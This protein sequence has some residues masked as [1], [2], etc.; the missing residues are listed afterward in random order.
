MKPLA[1]L[2]SLFLLTQAMEAQVYPPPA[3]VDYQSGS[4]VI[5]PPDSVPSYTGGLLGY[6]IYVDDEFLDFNPFTSPT[7]TLIYAFNPLPLPGDRVFCA[8]AVYLNWISDFTCDSVLVYYG[9]DIPFT[10]DWSS[11]SLETNNWTQEDNYW[12]IT[13]ES[14]NPSP[15]VK[16]VGSA[17]LTGYFVPLTSYV[18]IIDSLLVGNVYLEFDLK[19]D[20]INST[21]D[22]KLIAQKWDWANQQWTEIMNA[23]NINGSL[24]WT[25]NNFGLYSPTSRLFKIRFVAEGV[26]STDI[27]AW[28]IDNVHIFRTCH[29]P[30]DLITFF[31]DNNQVEL[32]WSSWS[33]GDWYNWLYYCGYENSTSIGT[34]SQAEFDVAARWTPAQLTGYENTSVSQVRFYPRESDAVYWIRIWEGD[35][36]T[37]V[38]EQE[39]I[40]PLIGQENIVIL[41]NEYS[42]DVTQTLWIGYHVVTN[43]GYP[44]GVDWGPPDDGYGNMM[45]WEGQ[46]QT[47]L[48]I[49][50]GLDYNWMII[51][52]VGGGNPYY[53][54]SRVYR[55]IN[56]GDYLR[57]ADIPMTLIYVD[58]NVDPADLNCYMVTDVRAKNYDTCESDYSNESCLQPVSL[59][60]NEDDEKLMVYPNPAKDELFVES[61]EPI[62]ELQ[63]LDMTG[64]VVYEEDNITDKLTIQVSGFNNGI[65]LL[66][67]VVKDGLII[68][69]VIIW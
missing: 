53:C 17:G 26:N 52:Y 33:C 64:W 56:N 15:S 40:D 43:T 29:A 24:D 27:S 41:D 36:A 2:I 13:E 65:Y 61:P 21:G 49:D 50:P 46:W 58:E 38:Y 32:S 62:T 59:S 8:T 28:Y 54:G 60:E 14:G 55:K 1:F 42:I 19:L 68:R 45:Y 20:C 51:A 44:A 39:V 18:F 5:C 9:Y 48:E 57:I 25:S 34:G 69:K 7:D 6:N 3:C 35:S 22:E 67:V 37:L 63:I 16:F 11:G 47:L 4:L 31:N 10:E 23:S 12:T 66:K 30:E